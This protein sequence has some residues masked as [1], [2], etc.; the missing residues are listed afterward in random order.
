MNFYKLYNLLV[1]MLCNIGIFQYAE[2]FGNIDFFFIRQMITRNH[3]F[4]HK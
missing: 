2:K 3:E 1:D 4:G